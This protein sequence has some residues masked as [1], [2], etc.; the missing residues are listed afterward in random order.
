[1]S[2]TKPSGTT[3]F[4]IEPPGANGGAGGYP[5][6][7]AL[8]WENYRITVTDPLGF[9]EEY[10]Y[11]GDS[12]YGWYRDKNQYLQ[13]GSTLVALNGPKTRYDYSLVSGQG[14][15]WKVVYADGKAVTYSNFNAVRQPQTVTDENGHATKLTYNSMG[16]VLTRA[17]ARNAPPANQYMTTYTYAP[18][19][20][21]LVNVTDF[22]HDAAHPALQ[23]GY[24]ANR[25]VTSITDGLGR[26]TGITRNQFGQ[27]ST[28]TDA[29]NQ[30]RTNNY[31]ALHRLTSVTQNG[32]TLVSIAPDA[33]GR[34]GSVTNANGDA[35]AYTYD[36]LNRVL[37]VTYPDQTY[38]ENQW[39]CCHLDTQRDRAGNFTSF[40][41]NEVNRLILAFDAK[42]RVTEYSYD[43]AG[44]PTKLVDG[45]HNATQW[46]YDNRNRAAKKVYVGGSFYLYDYDGV[47]NVLHQTD[48]KGVLTTYIYDVV[49][50]LTQ[51]LRLGTIWPVGS[52]PL[53]GR[54]RVTQLRYRTMRLVELRGTRS[55]TQE[56]ARS[57]MTSTGDRR[58]LQIR[59]E[60]SPTIIQARY[61]H[62]W[63]RSRQPAGLTPV[64]HTRTWLTTSGSPRSGTR[65]PETRQSQSSI[66][67]TTCSARSPNGRSKPVRPRRRR[68]TLTTIPSAS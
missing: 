64:S 6:P 3:G 62:F 13:G 42:N 32:N 36:D 43:P 49:N 47:G 7:G 21:D 57:S 53:M 18:N 50:N 59:W 14:V 10:Y 23:I 58:R 46:Q 26:S 25:N 52:P 5:P 2:V 28:V 61:R 38:S 27:T 56:P 8:M 31:N 19:N 54:G 12:R 29:T 33:K 35:V 68:I 1:T 9:K 37:R 39:G 44:N 48:A 66:T 16:R 20:I 24:D 41:Y 51:I 34:P 15:V 22:F 60:R 4:Y 67:N 30:T 17:D 65:I 40:I 11:N 55:T 63:R 45:N